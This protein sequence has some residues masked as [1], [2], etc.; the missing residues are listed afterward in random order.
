MNQY[1]WEYFIFKT[2]PAFKTNR[3]RRGITRARLGYKT[4]HPIPIPIN[5]GLVQYVPDWGVD[6]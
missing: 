6:A 1:Y 4:K 2:F 3:Q 5:H